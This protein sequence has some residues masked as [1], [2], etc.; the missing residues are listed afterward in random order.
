MAKL[1]KTARLNIEQRRESI[2]PSD[3]YRLK[4]V[5]VVTG[6]SLVTIRKKIDATVKNGQWLILMFHKVIPGGTGQDITPEFFEQIVDY[7]D[8]I[9]ARVVT[10]SEAI[11]Q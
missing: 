6:M 4:A 7:L 1:Y 5:P 8:S 10:M 9:N 11:G 2:P 3:M